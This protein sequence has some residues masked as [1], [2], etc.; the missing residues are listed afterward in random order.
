MIGV[1]ERTSLGTLETAVLLTMAEMG[2]SPA[3]PYVKSAKVTTSVADRFGIGP[4]Y[5]YDVLC[6]LARPWLTPLPLVDFH[7]NYGNPDFPA[8][9][10]AWTESRLSRVGWLAAAAERS[11][12]GAVPLGL[13]NGTV[14]AGGRW[15]PFGAR[16]II[17]ALS[18]ASSI[19]SLSDDELATLAGDPLFPGGCELDGAVQ[20]VLGGGRA[21]LVLR[22]RLSVTRAE[23]RVAIDIKNL[24]PAIGCDALTDYL[25]ARA[26]GAIPFL[27][28]W[29]AIDDDE[30][31]LPFS[32]VENLTHGEGWGDSVLVRCYLEPNEDVDACLDRLRREPG[33]TDE[34]DAELPQPVGTLLRDW[35][36]RHQ[37]GGWSGLE[38]LADLVGG[39]TG[40]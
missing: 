8:A 37:E 1:S 34:V 23:G 30:P 38:Q 36:T 40:R 2:L 3:R 26:E 11:E 17:E 19:R 9:E 7:G 13:I 12:V 6:D 32:G 4:R 39:T 14:Y 15:P 10:P 5:A 27:P 35:T 29:P 18:K 24:P 31:R 22:A 21:L 28:Y 25:S 16:R 20:Q 33:V